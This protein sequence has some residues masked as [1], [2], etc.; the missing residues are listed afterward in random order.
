VR[1]G[2]DVGIDAQADR[3]GL[4]KLAGDGVQAF[5][6]GGRFDVEAQDAG[7][8]RQFH[9]SGGLA[10]TRENDALRIGAGGQDALEFAGRDNVEAGAAAR[11]DVEHGEV[12]VGFD[13]VADECIK[14]GQFPLELVERVFQRLPRVDPARGAEVGRDVAQ[15]HR[16]GVQDAVTGVE[17]RSRR[18]LGGASFARLLGALGR[19]ARIARSRC[20]AWRRG[21]GHWFRGQRQSAFAAAG[22]E[23]DGRQHS[24]RKIVPHRSNRQNGKC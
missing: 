22:G 10:D 17:W 15:C 2:V 1:A 9:F 23:R 19:R 6:F 18:S 12:G 8:Q 21:R 16:L 11:Q 3:R 20:R 13:G 24:Q 14:P 4:A 7:V 5:K